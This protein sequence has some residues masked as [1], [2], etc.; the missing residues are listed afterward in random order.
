MIGIYWEWNL[1]MIHTFWFLRLGE[2]EVMEEN[3]RS[4]AG[5]W[6]KQEDIGL[7]DN[8]RRALCLQYYE[9]R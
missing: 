6:K 5:R 2:G 1:E 8:R 3:N 7:Q 9:Y 4:V